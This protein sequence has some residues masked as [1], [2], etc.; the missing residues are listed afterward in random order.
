MRYVL[1]GQGRGIAAML[2]AMAFFVVQDTL[3]KLTTSAWPPGQ[4]LTVRGC[5]AMTVAFTMAMALGHRG[6]LALLRRKPVLI[7]SCFETGAAFSFIIALAA[8]P[9]ADITAILLVTPLLITA[10]S[11]VFL[12]EAVGW[13]RWMAVWVGLVGMLLVVQP[14]ANP[15]GWAAGFAL[16]SAAFVATRDLY[17]RRIAA[18]LPSPILALGAA[19]GS[20][21][22]GALLSTMSP[23]VTWNWSIAGLLAL[24]SLFLVA[25]NYCVIHAFRSAETSLVSPFRYTVIV[26]A[27]LAGWVVFGEVPNPLAAAGI[28]LIIASGLYMLHRERVRRAVP[29]L[30]PTA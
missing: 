10:G 13:R 26:W 4:V 1:T 25:A 19:I 24:A 17:T 6:D 20:T 14:G 5:F 7:R 15:V 12:K 3:V 11:A 27:A 29:S 18:E 2:L 22:A 8:L 9:I 21:G 28:A 23:W 30:A 16:A